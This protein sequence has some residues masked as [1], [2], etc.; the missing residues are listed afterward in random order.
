MGT[1]EQATEE[2][3]YI[4][5]TALCGRRVVSADCVDAAWA[6]ATKRHRVEV[7]RNM[8]GE[9][10]VLGSNGKAVRRENLDRTSE[11]MTAWRPK[12]AMP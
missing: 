9:S 3:T 5:W 2:H 8:A 12:L 7:L 11:E 1:N 6:K 4:Y 10:W